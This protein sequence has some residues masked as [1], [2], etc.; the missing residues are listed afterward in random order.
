MFG[1]ILALVAV[2]V[3]P[4]QPRVTRIPRANQT[5]RRTELLVS[6]SEAV[7]AP[8]THAQEGP[9]R[10][11]GVMRG[12]TTACSASPRSSPFWRPRPSHW[13]WCGHSC[14]R[15]RPS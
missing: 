7:Q 6:V 11:I 8:F 10:T 2:L 1:Q 13:A 15:R 4:G 14:S 3:R 9:D 5:V 12:M